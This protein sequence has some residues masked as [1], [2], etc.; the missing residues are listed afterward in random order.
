MNDPD[1]EMPDGPVTD[2][3][4]EEE[5]STQLDSAIKEDGSVLIYDPEPAPGALQQAAS[6]I[7]GTIGCFVMLFAQAF[8]ICFAFW[9]SRSFIGFM[10]RYLLGNAIIYGGGYAIFLIVVGIYLAVTKNK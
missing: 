3:E 5:D 1:D 10:L 7:L 6:G 4:I 2:D 8:P 9:Y